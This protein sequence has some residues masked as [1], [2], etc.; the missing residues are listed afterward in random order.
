MSYQT[1]LKRHLAEYKRSTLGIREPGLYR[2]K[3]YE[4][5][6]PLPKQSANL[7]E[8]AE[9]KGSAFLAAHPIKRH[10]Y[11]HHLNSSQAFTFNLFFP[12]FC[13]GPEAACALLRALG[14]EGTLSEWEPEAVPVAHEKTNID[15]LWTKQ[16]GLRTY[17]EV[18]L[19]EPEFGTAVNDAGHQ[20]KLSKI[21]R[22]DLA[23][24]LE[25]TRLEPAAFFQA[26]Q[27]NRNVWHLVRTEGSRL[28]FLL[29]RSNTG[30]W[31]HIQKLILGVLPHT[32]ER[33][34]A[35]AIEDVIAALLAD[36]RCPH[37]L[38]GYAQKLR[39]KYLVQSIT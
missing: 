37:R 32:R 9:A 24:H 1:D 17:C 5:I 36:A 26:Y 20:D 4:H 22:P 39:D 21:Y 19:S 8:E 10:Q 18:K 38:R 15:V 30:L 35:V 28:I 33:I 16:A 27:F 29:P 23:G 25:P 13:G 7:L 12:Y 3:E 34:S 6:L 2:R 31:R 11:F 14:Q